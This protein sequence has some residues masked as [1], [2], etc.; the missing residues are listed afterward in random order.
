[1]YKPYLNKFKPSEI[2]KTQRKP[3]ENPINFA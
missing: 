3:N 1:M 2:N